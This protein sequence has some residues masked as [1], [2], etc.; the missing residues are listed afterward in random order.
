MHLAQHQKMRPL[1]K[2]KGEKLF[3]YQPEKS[4]TERSKA[5]KMARIIIGVQRRK[6]QE[7]R[8]FVKESRAVVGNPE[9]ANRTGTCHSSRFL[10]HP[11]GP[12]TN[13]KEG[14]TR[15]NFAS[16]TA[17]NSKRLGVLGLHNT[18]GLVSW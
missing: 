15:N 9:E 3:G 13:R 16:L 6:W 8:Y 4:E 11:E 17:S 18:Q 14:G 7:I 2:K 1:K 12:E 10:G 5:K